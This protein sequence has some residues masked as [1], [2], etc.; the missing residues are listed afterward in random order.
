MKFKINRNCDTCKYRDLEPDA[1]DNPC[2]N[3]K[4]EDM[5]GYEPK[6]KPIADWTLR[7]VK[8]Y[9]KARSE[10]VGCVFAFCES[11]C[12]ELCKFAAIPSNWDLT[13]KP[14]F[15]DEEKEWAQRLIDLFGDCTVC[16]NS[17]GE[18]IVEDVML[19]TD[20]LPSI[21]VGGEMKLSEIVGGNEK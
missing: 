7:E 19:H 16:R 1:T 6:H 5:P 10:C 9:C 2:W 15:T 18:L 8:G 4:G 13:N 21:R 14:R 3:C 17:I 20:V 12:D 11:G